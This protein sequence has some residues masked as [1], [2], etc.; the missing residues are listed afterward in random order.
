MLPK[1]KKRRKKNLHTK[2]PFKTKVYLIPDDSVMKVK[3]LD[4]FLL[5][6]VTNNDM[7]HEIIRANLSRLRIIEC[8]PDDFRYFINLEE[9]N[10]SE[11]QL[12][13]EQL[14]TF[15]SLIKLSMCA[16]GI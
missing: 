1:L 4:G 14:T 12:L 10:I 7:P 5:L 13:I 11:N 9:L 2:N 3:K 15:P 16:N 8:S 6:K